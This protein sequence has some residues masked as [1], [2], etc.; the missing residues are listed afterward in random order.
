MISECEGCHRPRHN[1]VLSYWVSFGGASLR[2]FECETGKLCP[3]CRSL[4]RETLRT[5]RQWTEDEASHLEEV[6]WNRL[7]D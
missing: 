3:R 2:D 7:D 5:D 1:L 6:L 4:H